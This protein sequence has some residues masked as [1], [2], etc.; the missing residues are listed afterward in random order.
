MILDMIELWAIVVCVQCLS[1][2]PTQLHG[3]SLLMSKVCVYLC[4]CVH[5]CACVC[6][7]VCVCV[8]VCVCSCVCVCACVCVC[9]CACVCVISVFA[10]LHVHVRAIF[11]IIQKVPFLP[12]KHT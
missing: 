9:V 6:V 1:R 7:C 10:Y 8:R 2:L 4:T 3:A 12:S 5:V 11:W